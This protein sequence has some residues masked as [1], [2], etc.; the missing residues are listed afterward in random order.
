[1]TKDDVVQ[2]IND[3]QW[4]IGSIKYYREKLKGE[5]NTSYVDGDITNPIAFE[6]RRKTTKFR[7]L[8]RF[9]SHVRLLQSQIESLE[10]EKEKVI[11]D[12]LLDGLSMSEIIRR[13]GLSKHVVYDVRDVI[14]ERILSNHQA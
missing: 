4:M 3:Y 9:E 11:Y 5:K 10:N 13:T 1:M 7:V 14:V 6:S 2:L 12:M 8:E